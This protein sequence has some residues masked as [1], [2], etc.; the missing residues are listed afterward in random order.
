[1]Q[2]YV[3][4]QNPDMA[5]KILQEMVEKGLEPNLPVYTTLINAFRVGRKL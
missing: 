2:V 4:K 5:E 1:M 3:W